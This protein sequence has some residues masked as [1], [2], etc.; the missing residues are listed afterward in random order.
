VTSRVPLGPHDSRL[1]TKLKHHRIVIQ[2]WWIDSRPVVA[3][4]EVGQTN[5]S[6][7]K[8]PVVHPSLY[9]AILGTNWDRGWPTSGVLVFDFYRPLKVMQFVHFNNKRSGSLKSIA[10]H[11]W[12]CM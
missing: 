9:G 11:F 10:Q 2:A 5:K 6:R 1:T 4:V 8:S 7:V 12:K 3:L